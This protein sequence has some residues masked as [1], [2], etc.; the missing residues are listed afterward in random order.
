MTFI[1]GRT[2]T[3]PA[4]QTWDVVNIAEGSDRGR[5]YSYG[6]TDRDAAVARAQELQ[7]QQ[8]AGLFVVAEEAG[9]TLNYIGPSDEDDL[10]CPT[11]G[12]AACNGAYY[13]D[14]DCGARD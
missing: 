3:P 10:L 14:P 6:I 1:V 11:C 2:A 5:I 7:E 8:P 13:T 12:H 9:D 4:A